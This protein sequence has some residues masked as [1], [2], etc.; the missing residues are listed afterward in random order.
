MKTTLKK[1]SLVAV[2]FTLFALPFNA[3]ADSFDLYLCGTGTAG[4]IPDATVTASLKAND[5]LIWQEFN[6][7]G[8]TPIGSATPINVV[9]NGVAPPFTVT[10]LSVGAHYYKVHVV[11]SSPTSCSGD[12]SP[13]FNV[14]SL[15]APGVSLA[16]PTA[17]FCE[18]G[19]N[20]GLTGSIIT[21]TATALAPILSDVSYE[22]TW[23]ATKDAGV[24]GDVT[25]IGA[26]GAITTPVNLNTFTLNNTAG[27]G[28]YIFKAAVK[29]KVAAG[30]LRSDTG[31]GCVAESAASPT[32][33][34]TPKPATPTI[35][36]AP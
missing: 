25:T 28:A 6:A 18:A 35:V 36:I 24:V 20:T 19:S 4:L 3:L 27:H 2:A 7:A 30:T 10:G 12:V 5:Q 16:A 15:P 13:A 26:I 29:Y 14:Y 32:I 1:L 33:T 9:T 31:T 22:F 34:V 8:T 23:T 17:T 21:A 11:T